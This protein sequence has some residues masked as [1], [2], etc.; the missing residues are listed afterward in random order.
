N[1]ADDTVTVLE[2][3]PPKLEAVATLAVG[4]E[5]RGVA[6]STDGAR[7]YIV[8]SGDNAVDVLD[9]KARTSVARISVGTEPWYA[10]LTPD[11]S[12]LVVGNA[13]SGD[14][15]L[16]DT[17]SLKVAATVPMKGRN[18]RH[19]AV[20]PDGAWAYLP[21]ITDR[22]AP[23]VLQNIERGLVLDN[24]IGRVPLAGGDREAIGLDTKGFGAGDAEGVA[25]SP[26]GRRLAITLGGTRDLVVITLP[27]PFKAQPGEFLPDELLRDKE[28]YRR[29]PGL[30]GRP[31]G[32]AFLPD[33][34]GVVVANS[35][36]NEIQVVDGD[37]GEIVRAVPLG[38]PAEPD[39]ARKG[40]KIFYDAYRSW[41][42]W[43]SCNTC[44]ADGHTNGG[45]Y[46][47][48]ADGKYGNP[49]KVLSLRGVTTTPPWTWHGHETDLSRVLQNSFTKTMARGGLN[50]QEL[51]AVLAYLKTVEFAPAPRG[52]PVDA[53]M[54]GAA[55]FKEKG[56]DACHAGPTYTTDEAFITGLEAPDDVYKGFNPPSLRGVTKRG[57]WLHDGRAKTL[58]EVLLQHHRPLKLSG[59]PD[60]TPA[61]LADLLVFLRSL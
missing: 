16:V 13:L 14:V 18:L 54:R 43:Y 31:L 35:L 36:G 33:G 21:H 42:E 46:D 28:R 12:R 10:A 23:T 9:L 53:V 22:G 17:A 25:V 19:V 24:R 58:K 7:A 2:V 34:K 50:K 60:F 4:N 30:R 15:S 59:K 61:E 47:T 8:V 40:E 3:A 5:P 49:K 1:W 27:A 29:I 32:C 48:L 38:G 11:G 37:T 45:L 55:S 26:D 57:P 6:I 20:S 56:C 41:H 44:H 51:S 39:L 52:L